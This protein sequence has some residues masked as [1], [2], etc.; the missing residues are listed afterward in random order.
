MKQYSLWVQ[1]VALL[2]VGGALVLLQSSIS[3]LTEGLIVSAVIYAVFI[4]QARWGFLKPLLPGLR[5]VDFLVFSGMFAVVA[6]MPLFEFMV[7][8]LTATG[9]LFG[10]IFAWAL[11]FMLRLPKMLK[12]PTSEKSADRPPA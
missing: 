3:P 5:L 12:S 2:A 8:T 6:A 4:Y 1:I 10:A 11:F 9:L 7:G